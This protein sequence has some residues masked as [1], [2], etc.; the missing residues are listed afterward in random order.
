MAIILAKQE[1][2]VGGLQSGARES[3]K[4]RTLSEK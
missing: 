1:V 4:Y 3:K 2:E